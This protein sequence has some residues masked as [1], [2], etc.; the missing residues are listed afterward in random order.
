MK[1]ET[2]ILPAICLWCYLSSIVTSL[3]IVQWARQ[4]CSKLKEPLEET[5]PQVRGVVEGGIWSTGKVQMT[6]ALPEFVFNAD[7]AR[8][9]GRYLK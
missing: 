4:C 3:P 7:R 2:N 6:Q 8:Y 5:Q 9:R 1:L